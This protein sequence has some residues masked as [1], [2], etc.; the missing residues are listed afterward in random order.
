MTNVNRRFQL[1][2]PL[3]ALLLTAAGVMA[4]GA[5]VRTWTDATGKFKFE[6][7]LVAH[8]KDKV[9]L[10]GADG[11]RVEIEVNR[12]SAADREYL[13]AQAKQAGPEDPFKPAG[14]T[15]TAAPDWS[16][17]RSVEVVAAQDTWKLPATAAP[18][19]KF[20]SLPVALPARR[21]FFEGCSALVVNPFSR[22][23]LVGYQW[24]NAGQMTSRLIYCD[25]EKGQRLHEF[26]VEGNVTPVALNDDGSRAVFKRN[27]ANK[28]TAEI[29]SL[30]E[31][32][33]ERVAEFSTADDKG[34][35][36]DLR[37]AVFLDDKRLLTAS[38]SSGKVVLWELP[39]LKPV[40][41]LTGQGSSVPALS[42]DRK[43]LAFVTGTQLGILDVDSGKVL[44]LRPTG[45]TPWASLSFSPGGHWLACGTHA[46]L[47]VWD[48]ATGEQ[49]RDFTV[50]PLH[51][52]G[53]IAWPNDKMMLIGNTAL[54]DVDLGYRFWEYQKH[55]HVQTYGGQSWFVVHEAQ[56]AII[57]AAVPDTAVGQAFDK[58]LADIVLK[59]GA[60]V[61]VNVSA[62]PNAEAA[63]KAATALEEQ[64][65][66]RGVKT[67]N[68]AG[69]ELIVTAD[70]GKEVEMQFVPASA[71]KGKIMPRLGPRGP[72]E[73]RVPPGTPV[74]IAK[75]REHFI[76]LKLVAGGKTLWEAS[77]DNLPK[78]VQL[79]EGE[80]LEQHLKKLER[81]NYAFC[82][83]VDLPRLLHREKGPAVLGSST[84]SVSGLR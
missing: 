56:G 55:N 34:Q 30:S 11:K 4:D 42:H 15:Q 75:I 14:S 21:H 45:R 48:L 59:P 19:C 1:L 50:N 3:A 37:W 27:V 71:N 26:I 70:E 52:W 13:A 80:T 65:T 9:T 81:P 60:A 22:R 77:A 57:P 39:A 69:V 31:K 68:D 58:A 20:Q 79:E 47:I 10:E 72:A 33:A 28:E 36:Q 78:S 7:K 64:L 49:H 62:L 51:V 43:L 18:E 74:R 44:A 12:L 54:M 82:E 24:N 29:W 66:K 5:A 53:Y 46:H 84:V 41:Q 25:L 40:Y 35:G 32:A 73:P 17:V 16:K 63:K 23:A 8:D 2:V 61:K 38:Y 76:R 67:A 83:T 6:G